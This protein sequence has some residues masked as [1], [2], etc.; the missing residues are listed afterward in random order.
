M[1]VR[2]E[3]AAKAW[4]RDLFGSRPAADLGIGLDDHDLETRPRK[5]VRANQAVVPGA[6]HHDVGRLNLA[7]S[8]YFQR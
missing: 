5:V 7:S 6:D 2:V 4:Q 3:I 1:E 8:D